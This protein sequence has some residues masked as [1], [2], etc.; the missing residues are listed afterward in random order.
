M[1]K[2]RKQRTK[3]ASPSEVISATVGL[4]TPQEGQQIKSTIIKYN[5]I[6][7]NSKLYDLRREYLDQLASFLT[8]R[9]K[10][11]QAGYALQK[12]LDGPLTTWR[13]DRTTGADVPPELTKSNHWIFKLVNKT[14]ATIKKDGVDTI[15]IVSADIY[16]VDTPDKDFTKKLRT[17]LLEDKADEYELGFLDLGEGNEPGSKEPQGISDS[18]REGT[19]EGTDDFDLTSSLVDNPDA[20]INAYRSLWTIDKKLEFYRDELTDHEQGSFFAMVLS[21]YEEDARALYERLDEEEKE[22][23][24][25]PSRPKSKRFTM[26]GRR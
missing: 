7:P 15:R 23:I 14:T 19:S 13:K 5:N 1:A 2:V 8:A 24:P 22:L 17:Y 26:G 25:E 6:K 18:T 10:L 21:R 11:Q 4:L 9:S 3:L 20:Y 16:C 12:A